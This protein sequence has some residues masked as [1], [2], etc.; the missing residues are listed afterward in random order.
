MSRKPL[1]ISATSLAIAGAAVGRALG[2]AGGSAAA[3]ANGAAT[4]AKAAK[5][6]VGSNRYRFG[7]PSGAWP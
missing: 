4:A 1:V 5:A 3:G 2:M 6:S 7:K